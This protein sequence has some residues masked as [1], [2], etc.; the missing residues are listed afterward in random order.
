MRFTS[1][2]RP[3][4]HNRRVLADL[5]RDLKLLEVRGLHKQNPLVFARGLRKLPIQRFVRR[6]TLFRAFLFLHTADNV[7]DV[8]RRL[9]AAF[10]QR[11]DIVINLLAEVGVLIPD[12][13]IGFLI[14]TEFRVFIKGETIRVIRP[15]ALDTQVS[16][17]RLELLINANRDGVER[18]DI[19]T[20][21]VLSE[22][23]KCPG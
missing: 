17:K 3:L 5:A 18:I 4:D 10:L 12:D 20:H 6:E 14:D 23:L 2:G 19:V 16:G 15:A 21:K 9:A 22:F 7:A 8:G 13:E 1:A 11:V